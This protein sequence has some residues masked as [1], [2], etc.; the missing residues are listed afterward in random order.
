MNSDG[1]D[2]GSDFLFTMNM[3]LPEKDLDQS[4]SS[5]FII[6]GETG[7]AINKLLTEQ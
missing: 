5:D 2:L 1:E 4:S 6:A 7:V 3:R